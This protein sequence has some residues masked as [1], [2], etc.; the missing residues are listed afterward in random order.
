MVFDAKIVMTEKEAAITVVAN[1]IAH[2]I[3][4]LETASVAAKEYGIEVPQLEDVVEKV[5]EVQGKLML[6]FEDER[7]KN[8]KTI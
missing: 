2:A 4:E 8:E 5:Q 1:I 7:R 6:L 3:A